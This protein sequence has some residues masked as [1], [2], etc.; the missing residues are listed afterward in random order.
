VPREDR[1]DVEHIVLP[2]GDIDLSAL[3]AEPD[4]S[5]AFAEQC[6]LRDTSTV[7]DG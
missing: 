3:L 5:L 2:P 4:T 7:A 6:L 1:I